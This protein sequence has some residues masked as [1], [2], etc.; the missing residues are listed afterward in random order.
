MTTHGDAAALVRGEVTGL[1]IPAHAEALR[2]AGA[3]FLSTAFRAFGSLDPGTRVARITRL[4]N[5]PGGSTGQ[6][7]FLSVEY[8]PPAPHLHTDLFVKF[9][10]DFSDP[11]RDRGRFEMASE[12]R[13]AALSRLA[14]FPVS[15]PKTYYADYHQD[16][17]TG[18]LITQRIP[19]GVGEIEPQHQ[20]CLDHELAD[21]ASYYRAIVSALARLAGAH[22]GGR[23]KADVDVQFPFDAQAAAAAD[24]IR[25]DE[26]QLRELLAAYAEF[27]HRYPQLLPA[28]IRSPG[29]LA[30]LEHDACRFLAHEAPIKRFLQGNREL[31]ALCHWNAH[32]DNAWFWRDA[33][34]A[35]QCGLIDWG[36][37]R[38]MN[39]A[40]ALWGSLSGAGPE[41][42][43]RHLQELLVLFAGE[44]HA[45]GG[46]RVD[47]EELKLH[48]QLY[49]A[50][51]GLAWML[52]APARILMRLPEAAGASGPRDPVFRRS[53]TARNQLHIFTVFLHLWQTQDFGA[54][55]DRMLY[56]RGTHDHGGNRK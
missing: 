35:L 53:E 52:E 18:V 41:V 27:A 6:K 16:S 32:I 1:T 42:W 31:V 15:V 49:I 48:L 50:T 44:Y 45:H 21:P 5:C 3:V 43:D 46:P 40:Y 23:L 12:V 13:F 4:E 7:L 56:I 38:Q 54:S 33:A 55:L 28:N 22:K 37:V 29:F 30:S 51:M 39:V 19:F 24:R 26:R 8:D 2:A 9:S 17:G 25:Y 36:R 14:H 34:G 11:L 20:K 47:V 10:R